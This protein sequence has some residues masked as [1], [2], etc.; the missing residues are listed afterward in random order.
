MAVNQREPDSSANLPSGNIY[1]DIILL[2][3][4]YWCL[5][6]F[7]PDLGKT[8]RGMVPAPTPI[9]LVELPSWPRAF[10]DNLADFLLR[11]SQPPSGRKA[12]L[13]PDVFVSTG[14]PW[15]RLLQSY[16]YHAFV[17]TAV[18]GFSATW[19]NQPVLRTRDPF[20]NSKITYYSVSEYLPPLDSG[21]TPAKQEL[22]SEPAYAKQPIISMPRLPDNRTQTIITPNSV[23]LTQEVRIPNLVAWT[24]VP[25]PVP[26]TAMGRTQLTLPATPV[27]VIAPPPEAHGSLSQVRL[28]RHSPDVVAPPPEVSA[29][30]SL[31][32]PNV[33]AP[34]VIEPPVS[35]EATRRR[36]GELNIAG[37][38]LDVGAPK[39]PVPEQRLATAGSDGNHAGPPGEA[40]TS[41]PPPPAV[42]GVGT[43]KQAAGQ[44]VALGL[45]PAPVEG[46]ISLPSGSRHGEFAATPEGKFGAPGTPDIKGGGN[47]AGGSGAG[48]G[49]FGHGGNTIGPAG[50]YVGGGPNQPPP[51]V[52]V[53]GDPA[54]TPAL[55]HPSPASN[56][57]ASTM[58]S[59]N[60]PRV[61]DPSR[62]TRPPASGP[63]PK[64]EDKVFAGK[65]YYSTTINM[66]NLASAGG[67]WI[68]RFAELTEDGGKG[69]V[70]APIATLKVDPKY[71]PDVMREG[72]EGTVT[73]Y[74]VIRKDG[75]VDEIRVLRGIDHRLDENARVALS[76]W[77]FRPGT[78][79][80]SAVDL[81]AVVSIPFRAGKLP[82]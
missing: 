49:G 57:G 28:P 67:S 30:S 19:L 21:S 73:L 41:V 31:K 76:R 5:M 18:W 13:W 65:R 39:L 9:L 3:C 38:G 15:R 64:I 36:V 8:A 80:G 47:G 1:H 34:A 44:L 26:T 74:A 29:K 60:P 55:P 61:P 82:F 72:V 23:R 53:A 16:L 71:P 6:Q 4:S 66:P 70:L 40:T 32:V 12:A 43:G 58:A 10:L 81:E 68:I 35:A 63:Q 33:P 69:E 75:S 56:P 42:T 37:S 51:G 78:K 7:N 11:P 50:I 46:P 14:A 48:D 52:V 77:H 17:I 59:V 62:T 2:P 22:K 27:S 20:E 54:S 45:N 79:N 25:A 24:P